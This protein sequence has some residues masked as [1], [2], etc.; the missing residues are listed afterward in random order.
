MRHI[1][2]VLGIAATMAIVAVLLA[3]HARAILAC[4]GTSGDGCADITDV[5]PDGGTTN[6]PPSSNVRVTMDE[7]KA[8]SLDKKNFYLKKQGARRH[9]QATV[10]A[11]PSTQATSTLDPLNDLKAGATYKATI[12]STYVSGQ[13]YYPKSATC[14]VKLGAAVKDPSATLNKGKITWTFQTASS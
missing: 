12:A 4:E 13:G 7:P 10:I 9:V 8:C 11:D 3:P 5:S 1:G 14:A 2:A 6:V